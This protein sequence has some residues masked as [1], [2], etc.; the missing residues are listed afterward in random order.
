MSRAAASQQRSIFHRQNLPWL[1]WGWILVSHGL[2]PPTFVISF[3]FTDESKRCH[4]KV[5]AAADVRKWNICLILASSY[6]FEQDAGVKC[7]VCDKAS[8]LHSAPME[9]HNSKVMIH[10]F[11]DAYCRHNSIFLEAN[12]F[13]RKIYILEPIFFTYASLQSRVSTYIHFFVS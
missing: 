11:Y 13:V 8:T 12:F 9:A 4:S 2:S 7:H 6:W 1:I 10:G 3:S 5:K